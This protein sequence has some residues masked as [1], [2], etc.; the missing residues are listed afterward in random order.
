MSVHE[1]S[2]QPVIC[3]KWQ[4]VQVGSTFYKDAPKKSE[5]G[6]LQRSVPEHNL[7]ILFQEVSVCDLLSTIPSL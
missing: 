3:K 6:F 7:P 4:Q 1:L 2:R 5:E